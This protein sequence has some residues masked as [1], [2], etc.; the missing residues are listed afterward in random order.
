MEYVVLQELYEKWGLERTPFLGDLTKKPEKFEALFKFRTNTIRSIVDRLENEFDSKIILLAG[1]PGVGKSTILDFMAR[2]L[3]TDKMK[4]ISLVSRLGVVREW[5]YSEFTPE[6][7]IHVFSEVDKFLNFIINT[8]KLEYPAPEESGLFEKYKENM[9]GNIPMLEF[10]RDILL[11]KCEIISKNQDK[12]PKYILAIDDVD[13]LFPYYQRDFLT[14]LISISQVTLNP[15]VIYSARPVASGIAITHL[16][17]YFHH[18]TAP[19][20][21]IHEIEPTA[22]IESRMLDAHN[23]SKSFI[24][25]FGDPEVREILNNMSNNNNLREALNLAEHCILHCGEYAKPPNY[26]YDKETILKVLYGFASISKEDADDIEYNRSLIN[27]FHSFE[28]GDVVPYIYVALYSLQKPQYINA[29]Y[30]EKFNFLAKNLVPGTDFV[31]KLSE[32]EI[33]KILVKCHKQYLIRRIEHVDLS[34]IPSQNELYSPENRLLYHK[35]SLT[36][37][38]AFIIELSKNSVYRELSAFRFWKPS[39]Q[40]IINNHKYEILKSSI[41]TIIPEHKGKDL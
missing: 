29:E 12:I 16:T 6:Q 20:I 25:P 4:R 30:F 21:L 13:Y 1:H 34:N 7:F 5:G 2:Y 28:L 40:N 15:L 38:G 35:V 33:L 23:K 11:P 8:N 14:A 17:S 24:N 39:I 19:P 3:F 18:M 27:I 32:T 41:R 22:I 26:I 37:K 9:N 31:K 36:D 10:T